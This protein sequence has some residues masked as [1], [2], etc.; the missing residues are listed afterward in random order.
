M[1]HQL[2]VKHYGTTQYENTWRA[3]QNFTEQRTPETIDEFWLVEHWPVFT[4]GQAGKAEHVL[5]PGNIPIVQS[6]RGGQVTY[7]GP[8]QIVLYI[9]IDIQRKTLA[10]RTLIRTLEQTI[11]DLLAQY[12]IPAATRCQAPGV[13]VNDAK[14][15]SLG[16]RIRRGYSYHGLSLN[17]T[18]DLEP[19]SRINPCGYRDLAVTQLSAF[20]PAVSLAMVTGDLVEHLARSLGYTT[21]TAI[22]LRK[23]SER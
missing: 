13:Y 15:A 5:N 19:F 2:I 16:L 6:D 14:I 20:Q 12:G 18:M 11:V 17:V 21:I 7:H 9:L 4:Q 8:G 22:D 1:Q 10:I 3:M 23:V